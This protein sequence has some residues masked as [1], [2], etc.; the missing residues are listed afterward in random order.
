MSRFFFWRLD[1]KY[2]E[3]DYNPKNYAAISVRKSPKY[4]NQRFEIR[5]DF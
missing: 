1:V 5:N 2:V 4:C 3:N